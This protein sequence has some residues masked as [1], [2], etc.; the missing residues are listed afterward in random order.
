MASRSASIGDLDLQRDVV[1]AV[2]RREL[3][4]LGVAREH[5]DHVVGAVLTLGA[6]LR[7]DRRPRVVAVRAHVEESWRR[8]LLL[9]QLALLAALRPARAVAGL[10]RADREALGATNRLG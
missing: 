10:E 7:F 6:A 2:L 1:D 9:G 5:F 3:A 8:R 4:R